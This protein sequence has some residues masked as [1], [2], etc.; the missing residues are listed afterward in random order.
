MAVLV[1]GPNRARVRNRAHGRDRDRDRDRDLDPH[2]LYGLGQSS[3]GR[4]ARRAAFAERF[5]ERAA[6]VSSQRAE[7]QA[8][9]A[10]SAAA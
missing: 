3:V 9:A 4:T 5:G 10:P 2:D 1:G 6:S 8:R 7:E